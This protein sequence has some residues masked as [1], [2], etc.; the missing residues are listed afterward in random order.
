MGGR[1]PVKFRL[2]GEAHSGISVMDA[3]DRVRLSQG[4]PYMLHD[5]S[6]DHFG[7]ITLKVRWN[8]YH[9][10]TYSIPL[11]TDHLGYL[12]SQSLARRTARA[13]AH[14]MQNNHILLTWDRV[15]IH[16]LE[17]TRPGIWIPVLTTH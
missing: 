14:F 3:L 10:N 9:S 2:S 8:G 5:M 4:R 17:E 12:D 16:R 13:I 6:P 15:V 11:S 1:L 7:K